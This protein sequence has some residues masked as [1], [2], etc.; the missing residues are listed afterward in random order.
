MDCENY[1][2]SFT[3]WI[4][5]KYHDI[6]EST[7]VSDYPL[8]WD[9][10]PPCFVEEPTG[11]FDSTMQWCLRLKTFSP[12]DD[13]LRHTAFCASWTTCQELPNGYNY[14]DGVY[15][16]LDG[17]FG[18][19]NAECIVSEEKSVDDLCV[20]LKHGLWSEYVIMHWDCFIIETL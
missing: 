16:C 17:W 2:W 8:F 12:C 7:R 19:A 15:V 4:M 18:S 1:A 11:R 13:F 14:T 20:Y 10:N 6:I 5:N 3:H 9:T